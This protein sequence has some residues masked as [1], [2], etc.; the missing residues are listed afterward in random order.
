MILPIFALV[1]MYGSTGNRMA[2]GRYPFVGDAACPR[3][4]PLETMIL[5]DDMP[6]ICTDR[7]SRSV[8]GRYDLY[9]TGTVKEMDQWG[10][11]LEKIEIM[12]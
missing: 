1:T 12:E 7:T 4:I 3:A 6:F 2:D 5:V 11:K 8:D 10:K 9:S